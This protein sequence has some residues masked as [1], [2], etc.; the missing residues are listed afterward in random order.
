MLGNENSVPCR[1]TKR[2]SWSLSGSGGFRLGIHN[3]KDDNIELDVFRKIIMLK[4]D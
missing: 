4:N 3:V 2:L 1:D